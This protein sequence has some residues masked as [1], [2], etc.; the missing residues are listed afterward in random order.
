MA[1]GGNTVAV[2]VL[3]IYR[4]IMEYGKMRWSGAW[5]LIELKIWPELV[6]VDPVNWKY[7]IETVSV[8]C[9]TIC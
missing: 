4:R 7:T 5:I 6:Q 1:R 8:R 3:G 9:I 2:P